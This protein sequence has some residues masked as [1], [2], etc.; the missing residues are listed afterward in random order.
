MN[1]NKKEVTFNNKVTRRSG[2]ISDALTPDMIYTAVHEVRQQ[3]T[4]LQE[5]RNVPR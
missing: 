3:Q 1:N 2:M 4:R 5:G